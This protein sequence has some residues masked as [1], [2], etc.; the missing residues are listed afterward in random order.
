MIKGNYEKSTC[1]LRNSFSSNA[2][3]LRHSQNDLTL[4]FTMTTKNLV[5]NAIVLFASANLC[6]QTQAINP[7][8]KEALSKTSASHQSYYID[9]FLLHLEDRKST[10][11]NSSHAN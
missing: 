2:T 3:A 9:P 1:R 11:L 4:S 7:V 8:A 6:G 5:A 10:R